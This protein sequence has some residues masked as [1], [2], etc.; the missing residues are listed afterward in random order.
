MITANYGELNDQFRGQQSDSPPTPNNINWTWDNDDEGELE[1]VV[2]NDAV[3]FSIQTISEDI[4]N[5]NDA[6]NYLQNNYVEI[7]YGDGAMKEEDP[8]KTLLS[9]D[10]AN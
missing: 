1:N 7:D 8:F 2:R 4:G 5:D 3:L 10:Q 6:P 9:F